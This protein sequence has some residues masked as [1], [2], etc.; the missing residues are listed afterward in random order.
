MRFEVVRDIQTFRQSDFR[1]KIGSVPGNVSPL[2]AG[3]IVP[4]DFSTPL[5]TLEM[6]EG[7]RDLR[8][9]VADAIRRETSDFRRQ[10]GP[11]GLRWVAF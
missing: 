7:G 9:E 3:S 1:R 10:T 6:T 8:F 4:G 5:P 2:T 11:S